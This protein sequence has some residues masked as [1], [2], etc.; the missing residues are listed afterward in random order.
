MGPQKNG[1]LMHSCHAFG[2]ALRGRGDAEAENV[3]LPIVSV[4]GRIVCR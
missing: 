4:E 2:Q 1:H 3:D